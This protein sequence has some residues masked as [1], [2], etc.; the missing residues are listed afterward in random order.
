MRNAALAGAAI[1]AISAVSA[2][3]HQCYR[4]VVEPPR[5]STV[6]EQVL[7]SPEREVAEYAPA[8][9]RQVEE[10]VVVRPE[11]TVTRVIPAQYAYEEQTVEVSPARREWRTRNEDGELIG[12]WVTLPARYAR[13][14]AA[15][16]GLARAGGRADDPG[17]DRDTAAH[18]NGRA[19]PLNH[20]HDPGALCDARARGAGIARRRALGAD[21]Q[22]RALRLTSWR[23]AGGS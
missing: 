4:R 21:R 12:C 22:L 19:R 8:V 20:A 18:R 23:G 10:T 15:S 1:L 16:A 11:R 17:A 6:E 3:A 5:Y 9:T 14:V 13:V 7:V 2:E